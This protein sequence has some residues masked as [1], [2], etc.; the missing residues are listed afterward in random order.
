[1]KDIHLLKKYLKDISKHP[2]LSREEEIELSK[3]VTSGDKK[4][5]STL[6]NGNL[7]LVVKI[8]LQ[9]YKG[10]ASIMDIIQNGSM[11]LMRAAE[12]YDYRK[13]VK[14]STYAAFW[15]KQAIL[16][17]FIKPSHS[18]SISYRKDA[19]NKQLQSFIQNFLD[20]NG[21]YPSVT[22]V[23]EEMNVTRR[24]AVDAL[25][26]M[27]KS[28]STSLNDGFSEGG[29]EM[30]DTIADDNYNPEKVVEQ[31]FLVEDV[32]EMVDSFPER[33][34]EIIRKRFG[35]DQD[36]KE[37]LKNLGRKFSVTAEAARQ[38]EKRVLVAM[39]QRFSEMSSYYL[40]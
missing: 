11:G 9:Y 34:K 40:S 27:K 26:A 28:S 19:I 2:L 30:I 4:A 13:E 35:F 38:I 31:L 3:K 16:R 33:E 14:F 12:K 36:N 29:A 10:S 8:A 15:I 6:V 5:L 24:D 23:V 20:K 1:M 22:E 21:L 7:R 18:V 25:F 39:R 32:H 37:T 17:G